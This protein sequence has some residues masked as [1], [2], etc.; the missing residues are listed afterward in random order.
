MKFKRKAVGGVDEEDV[1][2]KMKT[3]TIL[4]GE[5][6]ASLHQKNDD[7]LRENSLLQSQVEQHRAADQEKDARLYSHLVENV[8]V[9]RE[10]DVWMEKAQGVAVT[11]Q[12]D[13]KERTERIAAAQ[14]KAQSILLQ[15]KEC[16]ADLAAQKE[17]EVEQQLAARQ[18]EI[19]RLIDRRKELEEEADDFRMKLKA[20]LKPI[21]ENL[22][23]MLNQAKGLGVDEPT[24]N[25][26]NA[27]GYE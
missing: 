11:L 18:T 7:L 9:K 13:E 27:H 21:I 3:L 16:A 24:E 25:D 26:S 17:R 14:R 8:L 23:Q 6:I 1:L 19:K 12:W 2:S 10:R 15:A 22:G 5:L 4:Y 20:D